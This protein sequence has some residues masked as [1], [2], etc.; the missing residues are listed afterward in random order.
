MAM[1]KMKRFDSSIK[2]ILG[3]IDLSKSYSKQKEKNKGGKLTCLSHT[4]VENKYRKE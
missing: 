2:E 1:R 4:F 3:W